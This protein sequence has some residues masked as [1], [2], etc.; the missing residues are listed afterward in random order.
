LRA[1]VDALDAVFDTDG[2]PLLP[3]HLDPRACWAPSGPR[4]GSEA[5]VAKAHAAMENAAAW[6]AAVFHRH[7][8]YPPTRVHVS[9][10][11]AYRDNT[12]TV[13]WVGPRTGGRMLAASAWAR[14]LPADLYA[15]LAPALHSD[16]GLAYTRAKGSNRWQGVDGHHVQ[17]TRTA[18]SAH[19]VL[20]SIGAHGEAGAQQVHSLRLALPELWT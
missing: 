10:G 3:P 14:L 9:R 12:A 6:L 17:A 2:P 1:S 20:A 13:S 5:D 8:T 19:A 16:I 15:A 4:L 11:G 7:A 18:P